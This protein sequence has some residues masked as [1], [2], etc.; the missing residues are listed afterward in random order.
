MS[1]RTARALSWANKGL[2][3][4]LDQGLF[5]GS[6][7]LMYILLARWLN[8]TEY[9]AFTV[10]FTVFL[11]V[12]TAHTGLLSEPMLVFGPGPYRDNLSGYIRTLLAGH[13]GF[14]LVAAA[15]LALGAL[16][17]W[18]FGPPLLG[19]VLLTLSVSQPFILFSWLARRSFYI[20]LTPRWAAIAGVVYAILMIAGLYAIFRMSLL[21]PSWALGIMSFASL[22]AGAWV[23]TR[24]GVNIVTQP[25]RD[26]ARD[27]VRR[28][29]N[30]GRWAVATGAI[31]WI[32]G[33]LPFIVLS[34]TGGL[35]SSAALKA[36]RNLA[37]PA[38]H[39]YSALFIL[40]V[41]AFVHARMRGKLRG[42]MTTAMAVI[43]VAMGA[44]WTFLGLAGI[45]I[46]RWLYK[47]Q[48]MEYSHLLW[49]MGAQP[50]VAGIA[51]VL[52]AGLRALERP[53]HVFWGY[54]A[55]SAGVLTLGITFIVTL[56]VK[57]AIIGYIVCNLLGIAVMFHLLV[58][59]S[60]GAQPSS[61]PK[62]ASPAGE[63]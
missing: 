1:T 38:A 7:F 6:N 42:F 26:L 59:N 12:G 11:L 10:A 60:A 13:V 46:M 43:V 27:A 44:Y 3:T 23:L 52:S 21:T 63:S 62:P 8:P 58:T 55:T 4:V 32:P 51:A 16:C 24:L 14:S 17:T 45:P 31:M 20:N 28:H 15:G 18:A 34:A 61:S 57:G 54:L 47:G 49:L 40:M 19:R 25:E 53:H 50:L 33:Q 41:P 56:Q 9:G 35:A 29:W 2:W 36:L 22:V 30:Y 37:M 48:Y 5:A 39:T